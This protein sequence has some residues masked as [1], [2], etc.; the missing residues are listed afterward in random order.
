MSVLR[1]AQERFMVRLGSMFSEGVMYNK[2]ETESV[3]QKKYS[4]EE[5]LEI[6]CAR[7]VP[8]ALK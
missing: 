2:N 6:C 7:N 8:H 5:D 4:C 3:I 1:V